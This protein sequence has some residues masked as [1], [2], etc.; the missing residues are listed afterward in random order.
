[1]ALT[2]A[3]RYFYDQVVSI[4]RQYDRTLDRLHTISAGFHGSLKVGVGLYEYCSTEDF[5]SRFL[6]QH[7]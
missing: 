7:P 3:G 4:Q 1:M 6:T 5:F 2:A